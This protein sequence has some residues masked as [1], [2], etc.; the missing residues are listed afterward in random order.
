[1]VAH[2][3]HLDRSTGQNDWDGTRPSP[4]A[5]RIGQSFAGGGDPFSLRGEK[6]PQQPGRDSG[7]G[8]DTL[9]HRDFA[10]KYERPVPQGELPACPLR[11]R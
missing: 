9:F 1:M 3:V 10:A 5:E 2:S 6:D 11:C 4:A 7:T 8:R